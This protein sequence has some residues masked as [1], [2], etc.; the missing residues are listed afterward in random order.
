VASSLAADS[1][2]ARHQL[3]RTALLF[4]GSRS[5]YQEPFPFSPVTSVPDDEGKYT[6]VNQNLAEIS[7]I[8]F[9]L[10]HSGA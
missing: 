6:H 4:G 5:P 9:A 7:S 8:E 1:R 2:R 10:I 3:L